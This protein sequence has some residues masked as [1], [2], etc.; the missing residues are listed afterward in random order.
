M[1][2]R[3]IN[4]HRPYFLDPLNIVQAQPSNPALQL[5]PE[6][7]PRPLTAAKA[8]TGIRRMQYFCWC[9]FDAK[10]LW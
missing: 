7:S 3:E 9:Y 1:A 10:N 8:A 4:L 2:G 5:P 6:R